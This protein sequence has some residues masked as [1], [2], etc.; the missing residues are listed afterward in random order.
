MA[1]N[2]TINRSSGNSASSFWVTIKSTIA[3]SWQQFY[4]S[5]QPTAKARSSTNGALVWAVILGALFIALA[6]SLLLWWQGRDYQPLYGLG[7]HYS[8]AAIVETLEKQGI[9]YRINPDS[10]Q[11]LVSRQHIAQARMAMATA[12][13]FLKNPMLQQELPP[14]DALGS[15]HFMEQAHYLAALEVSLSNT[16]A[17]LTAVRSVR[18]HLAVPERTVF[19]REQPAASAS[20]YLD[21]YGGTNLTPEQVEAIMRLV[22]SSVTGLSEQQVTVVDQ[23]GNL[24]SESVA[25]NLH[26]GQNT[27]SRHSLTARIG[28]E[29]HIERQLTKILDAIAGAGNYRVDVAADLTSNKEEIN[30]EQFGPESVIRSESIESDDDIPGS[31]KS[32]AGQSVA[33]TGD[34]RRFI[35]RSG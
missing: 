12:G 17:S 28:I 13:I 23:Y 18:V 14:R 5:L 3:D 21:L 15:S 33:N 30:S 1:D 31:S 29:Q 25:A 35:N 6:I 16:I 34:K 32:S 27:T 4:A 26:S 7:E 8:T 19:F 11:L 10:G 2:A 24:L 9:H 22:N 20:V